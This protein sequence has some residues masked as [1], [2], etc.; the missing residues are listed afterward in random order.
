MNK[1]DISKLGDPIATPAWE[2][3]CIGLFVSVGGNEPF[4][5]PGSGG[6]LQ[7]WKPPGEARCPRL[8]RFLFPEKEKGPK[9]SF[10]HASFPVI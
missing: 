3:G 5:T 6:A 9:P 4:A 10:R 8:N 2:A 1:R 7:K